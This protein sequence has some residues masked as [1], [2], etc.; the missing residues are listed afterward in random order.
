MFPD[1]MAI[2]SYYYLPILI[3]LPLI[4]VLV[5][6]NARTQI[7]PE[8]PCFIQKLIQKKIVLVV[9]D[10]AVVRIKLEKILSSSYQVLTAVNGLE[11]LELLDKYKVSVLI[12]DLEMPEMDGFE[13][14]SSVSGAIETENL[15]IIA[16]TSHENLSAKVHQI[17]GV[18]G[19]FNK[20]WNDR[21]LLKRVSDLSKLN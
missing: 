16:I 9:D 7:I 19:I 11:A 8:E 5:I 21:D 12:T 4:V 20:P 1:A 13:L 17:S 2:L 14:I 3:L 15:P 18:Y 6:V 10:S